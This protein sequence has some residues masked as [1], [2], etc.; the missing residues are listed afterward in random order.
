VHR[1]EA[2]AACTQLID[3]LKSEVPIW[4]EQEFTTGDTA[5]VGLG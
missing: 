4:K 5:W 1:A 3:D 2:L